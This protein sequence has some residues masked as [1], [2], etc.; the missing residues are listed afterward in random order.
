MGTTVNLQ[1]LFSTMPV[2]QKEFKRNIKK[3]YSKLISVISSYGLVA[4]GVKI[5]VTNVKA[6]NKS[7]VVLQTHGSQS[8]RDNLVNIFG[9]K[10]VANIKPIV[11]ATLS[12]EELRLANIKTVPENSVRL[13]GF[14]SCH[15]NGNGR[16]APDRQFYFINSR[17]CDHAKLFK[18]VNQVYHV[19][20]R[21][22][23]PFVVLNIKTKR[24]DIDIN[25]TPDKRQIFLSHERFLIELIKKSL[26]QM[27]MDAPSTM[28]ANNFLAVSK[29]F[30]ISE[31]EKMEEKST[32]K[33]VESL[34]SRNVSKL[35]RSLSE[36]F[37]CAGKES[38]KKQ[39]TLD[40]FAGM[41]A[42]EEDCRASTE[43]SSEAREVLSATENS[44][45]VED[46][47]NIGEMDLTKKKR[48]IKNY[49]NAGPLE[50][51][52]DF[53]DVFKNADLECNKNIK[54]KSEHGSAT[55]IQAA[56]RKSEISLLLDKVPQYYRNSEN[57]QRKVEYQNG[58]KSGIKE[59]SKT[60]DLIETQPMP[61]I[62]DNQEDQE[63]KT[64]VNVTFNMKKLTDSLK[65]EVG[66]VQESSSRL[67]FKSQISPADNS[68]A[69]N[70]LR[71]QLHKTD[72]AKMKIYG[73][74]N[75]GF[76]VAGLDSDLFIIDQHATDEKYNFETLQK[77]TVIMSQKM[78]V[79]QKLELTAVNESILIENVQMFEKNGFTFDIDVDAP[80]SQRIKLVSLPISRNWIFGKDD[81][82]E[83]IFMLSEGGTSTETLRPSRV[84]AMFA[85]R[86]CRSSVMIGRALSATDMRKIVT[87]MGQIEQPWNCPHGRPTIRHL[88]NTN[89]IR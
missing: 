80:T 15:N 19:Y 21:N 25:V 68:N 84:R 77:T 55:R 44:T 6:N 54:I 36:S 42:A 31:R 32:W 7:E 43:V 69:E 9:V 56:S 30:E 45:D 50:E 35:K 48:A 27:Y 17:P 64:K 39:R 20:N 60:N 75:L 87:H 58:S 4:S 83:L 1:N 71:K 59:Y 72:F 74:F 62:D 67:K 34:T 53:L 65:R 78:V 86:A 5:K 11:Q 81:I 89:M 51:V 52:K 10:A 13:E 70:E 29:K 76:I 26:E 8:L 46:K 73:Q 16:G 28:P 79:P 3:E 63:I 22:Q 38:N 85:S 18:I 33:A 12:E 2:R 14:I 23:Y 66:E 57:Q 88:I 24:D 61:E 37:S 41:S 40:G 49:Q 82:D 47:Q